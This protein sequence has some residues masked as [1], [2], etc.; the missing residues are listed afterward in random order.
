[1]SVSMSQLIGLGASVIF[2][3]VISFCLRQGTKVRPREGLS[4]SSYLAGGSENHAD[5]DGGGG[6][7]H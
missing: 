1:M 3:A 7:G 6:S 4:E 2:V 5:S